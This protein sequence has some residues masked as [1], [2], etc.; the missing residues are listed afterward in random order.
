MKLQKL[1][2]GAA[3]L[4]VVL[5][6]GLC[7]VAWSQGATDEKSQTSHRE[8]GQTDK[9]NFRVGNKFFHARSE[10]NGLFRDVM[11]HE[12]RQDTK[13]SRPTFAVVFAKYARR[14]KITPNRWVLGSGSSSVYDERGLKR[15]MKFKRLTLSNTH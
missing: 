4:S 1:L 15:E 9:L 14:E 6:S 7:V 3:T 5:L 13:T 11:I 8:D 10:E 12:Q 2:G